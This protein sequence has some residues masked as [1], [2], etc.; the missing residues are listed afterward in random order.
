MGAVFAFKNDN[1]HLSLLLG[2]SILSYL[3]FG[4]EFSP[5][6]HC[7]LSYVIGGPLQLNDRNEAKRFVV[8]ITSLG[9]EVC[10]IRDTQALYTNVHFYVPW[11]LKNL[12]P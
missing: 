4:W 1:V 9:P 8:G 12:R 10:G 11:I 6:N 2:Q 5:L 3:P 7:S